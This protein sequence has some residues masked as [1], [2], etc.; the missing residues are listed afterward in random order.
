LAKECSEY[1]GQAGDHCTLVRSNVEEIP[2]GS[3]VF[4][5]VAADL[6]KGTYD[7]DVELRVSP[8]NVAFGHCVVTDLFAT[9]P[10]TVVG[11][12]AFAGGTGR[13]KG[14][15][16]QIVVTFDG[17]NP[18][19]YGWNGTYNF[20]SGR[21]GELHAIK[22]CIGTYLGRAGDFCTITRS[23]VERI[24]LGSRV[25]YQT[26]AGATSLNSDVILYPPGSG[27]GI[28]FGHCALD[29]ASG[30]GHCTFSGGTGEF[31]EFHAS[32]TVTCA[33]GI[34]ALDGTY[35]FSNEDD[36]D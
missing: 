16:A 2:V 28:A 24:E 18:A 21:S 12:C 9:V 32:V 19:L 29:F 35:T 20:T 23:N 31:E 30:L 34:C 22:D 3:K 26:A 25:V 36:E 11:H 14:F 33:Q 4:Y 1:R 13:F 10:S 8:G 15:S 7:G 6:K 27:K 17:G 5:L